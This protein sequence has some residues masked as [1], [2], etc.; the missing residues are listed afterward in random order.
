MADQ[1]PN[2][3]DVIA[4]LEA[5]YGDA[6]RTQK[7]DLEKFPALSTGSLLT[8]T[9]L[10]I[11]GW[12]KG[13][14]A[15]VFG[16]EG[17][18]KCVDLDTLVATQSGYQ[19]MRELLQQNNVAVESL[20]EEE[21]VPIKVMV[22]G[23]ENKILMG[24]KYYNA[25][26]HEAVEVKT[27]DGH[28][29]VGRSDHRVRVINKKG[30]VKWQSLDE[31]EKRDYIILQVGM[32]AC[33]NITATD[34]EVVAATLVGILVGS[35]KKEDGTVLQI[36]DIEFHKV[37]VLMLKN[38]WGDE[39]I[40][41]DFASTTGEIFLGEKVE[42]YIEKEGLRNGLPLWI[43][44]GKKVVQHAYLRALC[45][46]RIH[47]S[48]KMLEM[49]VF[50][51]G[52][53]QHT[54]LVAENWDVCWGWYQT[55][56]ATSAVEYKMYLKGRENAQKLSRILGDEKWQGMEWGKE[57]GK[58]IPNQ[59][60]NVEYVV[61]LLKGQEIATALKMEEEYES[62]YP[63]NLLAALL[64]RV[65]QLKL[66]AVDEDLKEIKETW[67]LMLNKHMKTD[68]IATIEWGKVVKM[69]DL[70]IPNAEHYQTAGFISHNS[71][72]AMTTCVQTAL[73]P[74]PK[75][76]S[77][78]I[79]WEHAFDKK[80][81][82][83]MGIPVDDPERFLLLQ[84]DNFEE[85]WE[86]FWKLFNT[87]RVALVVHDSVAAM[88]P[89]SAMEV[90]TG[91]EEGGVTIGEQSRL[92]KDQLMALTKRISQTGTVVVLINQLRAKISISGRHGI[93][94]MDQLKRWRV[95]EWFI[96]L[97]EDTTGGKTLR[98]MTTT[99]VRVDLVSPI[100]AET[101]NEITME[102][103]KQPV[104]NLVHITVVKHKVDKPYKRG[105]SILEYG[106]G[107]DNF[108]IVMQVAKAKGAIKISRTGHW[109]VALPKEVMKGRGT[110]D[111][112]K[113]FRDSPKLMADL[114]AMV[115]F[116]SVG[117]ITK[118]FPVLSP[119]TIKAASETMRIMAKSDLE[120]SPDGAEPSENDGTTPA[121]DGVSPED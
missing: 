55:M 120:E 81:G 4:E 11:G 94:T 51:E 104:G 96:P 79:D 18:G 60:E 49:T 24:S 59:K 84:P 27:F 21:V 15:E 26:E 74:P 6:V 30:R 2:L 67:Q 102:K 78:Y 23:V 93:Y 64:S 88:T 77:L 10:G 87:G 92:L 34:K 112:E 99:R 33:Q 80:Y 116:T 1:Q 115:N 68:Q 46:T 107:W 40:E 53:A 7:K 22:R 61:K 16:K 89:K 54:Q 58:L 118:M 43:R 113:R 82:R 41:E 83:K 117:D 100:M 90:A 98:Y 62:G 36:L 31:L 109:E 105:K 17:T 101:L 86:M 91:D 39:V 20:K 73:L 25:G 103:E 110:E 9:L 28:R 63:E 3:K 65:K 42:E 45:K 32:E 71:T 108:G 57:E 19:S 95:P 47:W 50:S 119:E 38:K 114:I 48:E 8:D 12:G 14:V 121:A 56:D 66:V 37:A 106:V 13:R 76:L 70:V 44:A 75:N 111:L 52:V 29:L 85:G 72:L 35:K 97:E 69:G 5:D